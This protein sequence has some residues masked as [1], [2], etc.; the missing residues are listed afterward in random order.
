[1]RGSNEMG[2]AGENAHVMKTQLLMF[3][4]QRLVQPD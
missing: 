4:L 3:Y 1:M 2:K